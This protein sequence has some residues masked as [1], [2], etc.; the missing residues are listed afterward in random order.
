MGNFTV[1]VTGLDIFHQTLSKSFKLFEEFSKKYKLN[2]KFIEFSPNLH[3]FDAFMGDVQRLKGSGQSF[4]APSLEHEELSI[5]V[6]NLVQIPRSENLLGVTLITRNFLI[7]FYCTLILFALIETF[8]LRTM[9]KKVD[10][11][12]KF[13]IGYLLLNGLSTKLPRNTLSR[14]LYTF[15]MFVGLLN[16]INYSVSF[17]SILVKGIPYLNSSIHCTKRNIH[18]LKEK[19]PN[20]KD[21][22]F[23]EVEL[24]N[25]IYNLINMDTDNGAC[26]TRSMWKALFNFQREFRTNIFRLAIGWI[27]GFTKN[28]L[29][30][31]N[32]KS[33]FAK[34]MRNF[35]DTLF[36]TG[37]FE[38]WFEADVK[39][40]KKLTEFKPQS[41]VV[42]FEDVHI[43]FKLILFMYVAASVIFGLELSYKFVPKICN[44]KNTKKSTKKVLSFYQFRKVKF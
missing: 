21:F 6:P 5:V 44:K 22:D 16:N 33:K 32:I 43:L 2:L 42:S 37:I 23:K 18:F 36:C 7:F 24:N 27:S 30:A 15:L 40:M 1:A 10:Y 14:F 28:S 4:F 38:K 20:F 34:E 11:V 29:L 41:E 13:L 3:Y 9:K 35:L 12:N 19:L 8:I 26:I 25:L 17:G 31:F 39:Y